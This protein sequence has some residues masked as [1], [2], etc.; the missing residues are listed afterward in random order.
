MKNHAYSIPKMIWLVVFLALPS[1]V[2]AL[3][4]EYGNTLILSQPIHENVYISGGT[5]TINAPIYGDLTVAGGTI[6]INDSIF[7]D[8]LMAGGTIILQGYIAQDLRAGAGDI[9]IYNTIAGDVLIG[10]GSLVL[11]EQAQIGDL[12]I[13]AG[14]VEINGT[15]NGILKAGVNEFK[16][17][18]TVKKDM[19][20]K[21]AT[22]SILGTVDGNGTLAA[23]ESIQCG[24]K[25]VFNGNIT[26][27]VPGPTPNFTE[28]LRPPTQTIFD[29]SLKMSEAT[30]Y[31]LGWGSLMILW[32]YLGTAL[33]MIMLIQYFFAPVLRQAV[34]TTQTMTLKSFLWGLLFFIGLPITILI[35]FVT[36]IGLP[37]G[38]ILLF[39]L[40]SLIILASCIVAVTSAQWFMIQYGKQ[41][42]FW[43]VVLLA[44][45][46]FVVFKMIGST[47]IIGWVFTFITV[48]IVFGAIL[49]NIRWKKHAFVD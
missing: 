45:G 47:P 30:W 41:Y 8:V 19:N 49:I 9:K 4:I 25:T 29:S 38:L 32:W 6:T 33:L 23:S 37:I 12:I 1:L 40:I 16:L 22:I 46:F 5:I 14:N 44:F 20:I 36:V 17:H 13:G 11:Y 27:W 39:A 31:K 15:V 7:G 18:G 3:K 28:A 43:Q 48:N 34:G 42:N 21:G 2:S 26:Y 10:S 24:S 35:T